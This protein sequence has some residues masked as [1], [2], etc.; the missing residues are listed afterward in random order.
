VPIE[1]ID[2]TD[3]QRVDAVGFDRDQET[4]FVRFKKGGVEWWYS[5]CPPHLWEQF[6]APGTSKG[7]FI[8]D[9]LDGHTNGRWTG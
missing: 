3:S 7:K 4:I 1:W 9:V 2:V 6:I 5:G 8:K